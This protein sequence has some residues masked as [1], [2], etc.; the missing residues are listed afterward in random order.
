MARI[1]AGLGRLMGA[2]VFDREKIL[3]T[4]LPVT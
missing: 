4:T 1:M 3:D 2:G